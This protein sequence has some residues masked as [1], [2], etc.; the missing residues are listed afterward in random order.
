MQWGSRL[1][2]SCLGTLRLMDQQSSVS[3]L[4]CTTCLRFCV[5]VGVRCVTRSKQVHAARE[6]LP[7]QP[8][9]DGPALQCVLC[10]LLHLLAFVCVG[11]C[12]VALH[13]WSRCMHDPLP[14][15]GGP[16]TA[17]MPWQA[18]QQS[19]QATASFQLPGEETC[20]APHFMVSLPAHIPPDQ[21]GPS[22]HTHP[23]EHAAQGVVGEA[24][25]CELA[26]PPKA[27]RHVVAC[28]G[29]ACCVLHVLHGQIGNT[30]WGTR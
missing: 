9:V 1:G 25:A 26:P 2:R 10:G 23:H 27:A 30:A 24:A 5:C 28:R 29:R 21:E 16:G 11:G 17:S 14:S 7:K 6:A 3:C 20:K 15:G 4:A 22:S 19:C 18:Q 13:G 8:R 12:T